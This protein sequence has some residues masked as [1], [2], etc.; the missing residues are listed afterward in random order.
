L[1]RHPCCC[2]LAIIWVRRCGDHSGGW[3]LTCTKTAVL[4]GFT[5]RTALP[6]IQ[7][8]AGR[9]AVGVRRA[10]IVDAFA[11][12]SERKNF[13]SMPQIVW[14]CRVTLNWIKL[15]AQYHRSLQ[16]AITDPLSPA[17][18]EVAATCQRAAGNRTV[19]AK[20]HNR[21]ARAH[22][23]TA[24]HSQVMQL[25][26]ASL[27]HC[28]VPRNCYFALV[29]MT[30]VRPPWSLPA[31]TQKQREPTTTPGC[32][33]SAKSAQNAVSLAGLCCSFPSY[34]HAGVS[35]DANKHSMPLTLRTTFHKPRPTS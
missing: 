18:F 32:W 31:R 22:D 10:C 28:N 11:G 20:P 15:Q 14:K 9:A 26:V 6:R 35:E 19:A 5:A 30:E 33:L 24:S 12:G 27:L 29:C 34:G 23:T 3:P 13:N 4:A 17:T 1:H 21:C 2:S 7:R 16:H 8:A 25:S